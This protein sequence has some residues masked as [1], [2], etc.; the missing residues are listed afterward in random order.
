MSK[1]QG[2]PKDHESR[3]RI[4]RSL[5]K[6]LVFLIASLIAILLGFILEV[7][8]A[9]WPGWVIEHRTQIE[10]I[11]LLAVIVLTLVSPIIVE[12][13]SNPRALSGPGKNPEG[14]RFQ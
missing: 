5:K 4:A 11:I 14:P 9:W 1:I 8:A 7:G 3:K 10:G 6:R 2:H 12:A 13:S